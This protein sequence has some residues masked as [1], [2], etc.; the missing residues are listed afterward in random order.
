MLDG[1]PSNSWAMIRYYL[2]QRENRAKVRRE[3]RSETLDDLI[4]RNL[5]D[6]L[7]TMMFDDDDDF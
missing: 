1:G 4:H 2:D 5:R 3:V 7:A 6:E